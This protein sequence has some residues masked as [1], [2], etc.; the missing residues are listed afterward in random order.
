M[1]EGLEVFLKNYR[2]PFGGR[3]KGCLEFVRVVLN[4]KEVINIYTAS[5]SA[6]YSLVGYLKAK[7]I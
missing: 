4:S 7:K 3:P 6:I 1:V 5:N 2:H